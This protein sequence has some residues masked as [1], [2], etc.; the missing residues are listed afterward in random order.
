MPSGP[1]TKE[2]VWLPL[3][4]SSTWFDE[5]CLQRIVTCVLLRKGPGRG[6][7]GVKDGN[8]QFTGVRED[9][10]FNHYP[11]TKPVQSGSG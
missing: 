1:S 3:C 2:H 8:V 4:K 10:A 6:G 11:L 5:G 9:C 7:T